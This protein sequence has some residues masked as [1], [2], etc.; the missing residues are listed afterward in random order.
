MGI[1]GMG[2]FLFSD[3]STP[4]L[5]DA[6]LAN[7]DLLDAFRNP[8]YT[9]DVSGRGGG[10]RRPVDFGN[11]GS[12]ELG[13]VY[14]SV[15]E[16]HPLIDTDEGPFTLGTAAGHE[17]KT[18]GNPT[19]SSRRIPSRGYSSKHGSRGN[20]SLRNAESANCPTWPSWP[21]RVFKL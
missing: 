13:S 4:D 15:L 9:E 7:Q 6:A 3:D 19:L 16:L 8:C 11:L 12:E 21:V 5:D 10:I 1:P 2:S 20:V 18:T 17:R 14:E